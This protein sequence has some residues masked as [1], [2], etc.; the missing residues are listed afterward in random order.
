MKNLSS[1][2]VD[3]LVMILAVVLPCRFLWPLRANFDIDWYNNKWAI[4]YAGE[5][6][7]HHW[8]MPAVFNTSQWGGIPAPIFYAKL[9]SHLGNVRRSIFLR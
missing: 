2:A 1:T 3:R 5:Y 8:A 7:R 9:G 4:G 6:F